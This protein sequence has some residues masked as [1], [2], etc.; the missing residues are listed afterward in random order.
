[1][2][3]S[4]VLAS[5]ILFAAFAFGWRSWLQWRR[6]GSTGFKGISGRIGSAEWFGGVLLAVA[7]VVAAL[8]PIA[9][10]AGW[11]SEVDAPPLLVVP[12][13]TL[14]GAG[15][16]G[17][18][19]AQLDMGASWRIGVDATE[20]TALVSR[21][22]FRVA[23]NP[24][25]TSMLLVLAGEALLVPGVLSAVA[26]IAALVGIELQV[27]LV[28]EPYLL[29]THGDSY[30]E[31]AGR[32]GRFVP[33]LGRLQHAAQASAADARSTSTEGGLA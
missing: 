9:V 21:G 20:R 5:L 14:L 17:T 18:L 24:I 11:S 31:Y 23:R 26:F 22:L 32:V 33:F 1:M 16:V 6:T 29:R 19:V 10:L 2:T 4:L 30:R 28:E 12:G 27:R 15:V 3:A 8:A 7:F 25:F 13:V